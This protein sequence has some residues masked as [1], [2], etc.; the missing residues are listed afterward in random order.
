[1]SQKPSNPKTPQAVLQF[2]TPNRGQATPHA[3]T[4]SALKAKI[5]MNFAKRRDMIAFWQNRASFAGGMGIPPPLQA[6]THDCWRLFQVVNQGKPRHQFHQIE[7]QIRIPQYSRLKS[8][9]RAERLSQS[10]PRRGGTMARRLP[11]MV[12]QFA[13]R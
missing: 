8:I 1:M 2:L 7:G 6:T 11:E 10:P 5:A 4:A 13:R 9:W 3:E 12:P